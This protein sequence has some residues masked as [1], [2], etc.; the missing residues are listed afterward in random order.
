MCVIKNVLSGPEMSDLLNIVIPKIEAKWRD[1]AHHMRYQLYEIDAIATDHHNVRD[2][3][4]KLLTDWLTTRHPPTPKT[5]QTLL[6]HLKHVDDL[7]AAVEE[8][9]K[10]LVNCK[11]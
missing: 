6:D 9:E 4:V 7:T 1:V 3:C 5:W 11:E 8:I 2:C 10:Q